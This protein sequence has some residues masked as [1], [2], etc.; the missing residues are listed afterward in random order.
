MMA[1]PDSFTGPINLG[2]PV[3]FTIRELAELVIELT[4]SSST[5]INEPLPADDPQQRQPDI[6]MAKA[7][8]G[9]E[10][11]TPLKDGLLKTISYFDQMISD[12]LA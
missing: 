7:E 1:T 10:P 9:W 11:V 6:G 4:H 3:E 2:N 8:L 5:L 12:G